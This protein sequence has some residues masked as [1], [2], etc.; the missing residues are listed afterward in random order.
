MK[1]QLKYD[2]PKLIDLTSKEWNVG[3]GDGSPSAGCT[4]GTK[5]RP[6]TCAEGFGVGA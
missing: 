5:P 6:L 3:F 2:R 1:R 4:D